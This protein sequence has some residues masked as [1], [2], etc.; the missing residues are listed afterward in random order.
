LNESSQFLSRWVFLRLLGAIYLIAFVSLWVQVDGLIGSAG[1]LPAREYLQQVG[2]MVGR[3]RYWWLP[4]LFWLRP[5][6]GMLYALCAA[7]SALAILLIVGVAPAP[8]LAGLWLAY[9]SLEAVGQEFLSFQWD[10]LLL[11]TGFLA[12]FLAPLQLRPSLAREREPAIPVVWLFRWLLFRLMFGSGAVKLLSGDAAWRNLTALEYHYWTQPLP[13]WIGWYANLLPGWFQRLSCGLMFV[14]E[15]AVPCMIWGGS[16]PRLAAFAAFTTLQVLIL[17]A[18]N[19]GFFNLL[20]IALCVLLLDDAVWPRQIRRWRRDGGP[21]LGIVWPRWILGP[22][23]AVILLLGVLQMFTLS[24]FGLD[25]P[26]PLLTL[27]RVT[28][29]LRIVNSYGLFAVMTTTRPEIIVEGSDDL[30][31][32]REYAFKWKPGDPSRAPAFVEPHQPRLDWQMWFAAL[33][34]YAHNPWFLA[35]VLRLLE[36]SQGVA[37]LLAGNPFP[38]HPPKYIRAELYQYGF[39]TLAERR[40]TGHWWKRAPQGLYLPAVS[41]DSFRRRE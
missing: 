28:A 20:T 14:I 29:P 18:G 37:A 5:T 7:G 34:D 6:D 9:R 27:R 39:T 24:R 25:W 12:I 13:T 17:L 3:W 38:E 16:G 15:L 35:F 22:V 40:A 4:T 36:G 10:T 8:C 21:P 23:A 33:G 31:E 11:E 32:W 41:L 1:I 19:Y 2:G 26:G 30:S